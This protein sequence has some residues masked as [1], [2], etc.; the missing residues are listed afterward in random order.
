MPLSRAS[1]HITLIRPRI[2]GAS[3]MALSIPAGM[4]RCA[5]IDFGAATQLGRKYRVHA[6]ERRCRST[7]AGI[8]LWFVAHACFAKCVI[9]K[10]QVGMRDGSRAALALGR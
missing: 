4:S 3:G 2:A 1:E 6:G 5:V 10:P 7:V 8:W 9:A